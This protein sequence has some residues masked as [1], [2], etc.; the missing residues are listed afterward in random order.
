MEQKTIIERAYNYTNE[1]LKN[2]QVDITTTGGKTIK[3]SYLI[4]EDDDFIIHSIRTPHSVLE[5]EIYLEKD[6][7][8][9]T[10]KTDGK[11]NTGLVHSHI[12]GIM[13]N[14]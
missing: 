1:L 14:Y 7:E 12:I 2:H 11:F 10:I 13:R 8:G 3:A 6:S 4:E 9:N 5:Q